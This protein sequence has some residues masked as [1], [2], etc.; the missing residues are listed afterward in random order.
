M[1]FFHSVEGCICNWCI[2]ELQFLLL[3]ELYSSEIYFI[4]N[5]INLSLVCESF[6]T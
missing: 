6:C 2:S 1:S 3:V 5:E 4:T